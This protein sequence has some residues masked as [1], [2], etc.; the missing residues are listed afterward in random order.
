MIKPLRKFMLHQA[1]IAHKIKDEDSIALFMEMRL[2]KTLI[3]IRWALKRPT[4]GNIL[5]A[6]PKSIL[7]SWEDELT[8]ENQEYTTITGTAKQKKETYI[9][10]LNKG[11]RW[12][13]VNYESLLV[14]GKKTPTGKPQAVPTMFSKSN[15]WAI[16]IADESTK[17][18]NAKASITKIFL[19]YLSYAP[20][21]AILSGLPNPEGIEDMVTQMIW[22]HDKFMDHNN[23]WDWRVKY[24][25]QTGFSWE[26]IN[27]LK[28][29]IKEWVNNNSISMTRKQVNLGNKKIYSKRFVELP[30]KVLKAIKKVKKDF[31][32]DDYLISN[33]LS[34]LTLINRLIGGTYPGYEHNK[35]VAELLY[36]LRGEL[37]NESV[38]VFFRF[39]DEIDKVAEGMGELD[40]AIITGQ[41]KNNKKTITCFQKGYIKILLCQ[42]KCVNMGIDLSISSTIIY[43]SNYYDNEKRLQSEDRIEHIKKHDQLLI[44]DIVA[45]KTIDSEII[46]LL[47]IKKFNSKIFI[48]ELLK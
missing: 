9:D 16:I 3:T 24:M 1:K 42:T 28:P 31:Q 47:R 6:A 8:L 14:S 26:I 15:A 40:Y 18:K 19:A 17:I 11:H 32:L 22:S 48:K 41:T 2:G 45:D 43:Y 44:I 37:K 35:K 27:K 30:A 5:V 39:N 33:A 23:Y 10:G 21:K 34:Q 36:L 38:V 46:D 4:M 7:K 29:K 13:I 20:Y 12:F 25:M